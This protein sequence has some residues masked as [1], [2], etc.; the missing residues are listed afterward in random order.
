[1]IKRVETDE[2]LW[3]IFKNLQYKQTEKNAEALLIYERFLCYGTKYD[4]C[5][6]YKTEDN[7]VINE[8][9][10]SFVLYN[11][12]D[13]D[14]LEEFF[15][16]SDFGEIFCSYEAGKELSSRCVFWHRND[17]NLMIFKGLGIPCETQKEVSVSDFVDISSTGFNLDTESYYVEFSHRVRHNIS[18]LRRLNNSVLTVQHNLCGSALIA[19]VATV[20]ES[21]GNGDATRLILSACAEFSSSEVY[22]LCEDEMI[23]FYKRIGFETVGKKCILN[24]LI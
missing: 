18:Q 22:I 14:E 8:M 7:C 10:N 6:F 15:A 4:F 13:F 12:K 20:P 16:Y 17:L 2:D 9:Y 11:G 24:N 5:K 3:Y 1:M 19:Q 23:D 21:R